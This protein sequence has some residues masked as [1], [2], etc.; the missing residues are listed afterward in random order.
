MIVEVAADRSKIMEVSEIWE[1]QWLTAL[2][3]R[4]TECPSVCPDE[5]RSWK[6]K[7]LPGSSGAL[8]CFDGL[9]W[10]LGTQGWSPRCCQ[11]KAQ[12]SILLHH[13][14]P[15]ARGT[16]QPLQVLSVRV[17]DH[18]RSHTTLI[19]KNSMEYFTQKNSSVD[20]QKHILVFQGLFRPLADHPQTPDVR[21]P[22]YSENKEC[23]S[24]LGSL[25]WNWLTLPLRSSSSGFHGSQRGG[26]RERVSELCVVPDSTRSSQMLVPFSREYCHGNAK[27]AQNS[28]R[29]FKNI[30]FKTLFKNLFKCKIKYK[31][32]KTPTNQNNGRVN[33]SQVE[34]ACP[35]LRWRTRTLP[36]TQQRLH[37]P[38]PITAPSSFQK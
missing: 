22:S 21:T 6:S 17:L 25:V 27:G 31:S 18:M 19:I 32:W 33:Y 35:P 3:W 34:S 30:F 2:R 26:A 36:A 1:T 28:E 12:R 14:G 7:D 24:A 13:S 38:Q 23:I 5:G 29:V 4:G 10:A 37:V 16:P 15:A 20:T 9:M 8:C 11:L